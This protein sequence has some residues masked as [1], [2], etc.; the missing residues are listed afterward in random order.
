MNTSYQKSSG[1][2]EQNQF[3]CFYVIEQK[4]CRDLYVIIVPFQDL[5]TLFYVYQLNNV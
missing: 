3:S 1:T 2:N 4:S 5:V